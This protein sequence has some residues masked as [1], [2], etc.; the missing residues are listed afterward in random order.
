MVKLNQEIV[1]L[2]G[3]FMF[4]VVG[5]LFVYQTKTRGRNTP[6]L[7]AGFFVAFFA[8][9]LS[10][11]EAIQTQSEIGFFY[12]L[13]EN[14][15]ILFFVIQAIF[16]LSINAILLFFWVFLEHLNSTQINPTFRT[17]VLF[18]F[19]VT[20]AMYGLG[21]AIIGYET[22]NNL[23]EAVQLAFRT[24]NLAFALLLNIIISRSI[25]ILYR[26]YNATERENTAL[27]QMLSF[28]SIL[29]WGLNGILVS[30]DR[31]INGFGIGD[32][33][34]TDQA[35]LAN[36]SYYLGLLIFSGTIVGNPDYIY[37]LPL[38][39]QDIVFLSSYGTAIYGIGKNVEE[40]SLDEQLLAGFVTAS[41]SFIK[42]MQPQIENEV[43]RLIIS[44]G[45]IL[46]MEFGDK[47]G[48]CLVSQ[49]ENL[50]LIRSIQSLLQFIE[51]QDTSIID[52]GQFFPENQVRAWLKKFFPYLDIDNMQS[53]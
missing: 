6:I 2:Y 14:Y 43:I 3:S 32:I 45:R 44:T 28:V 18:L 49:R 40:K 47:L 26:I 51:N 53:Y 7:T 13:R 34:Y 12:F 33:N 30:W 48:I 46:R 10:S 11:I 38:N 9:F 35:I 37:R 16:V 31:F 17:L 22:Q 15:F 27:F 29:I 4:L 24:G 21:I 36:I 52:A 41:N 42:E 25:L 19:G 50:Y 8:Q 39:I 5:I 23:I 20:V 1:D